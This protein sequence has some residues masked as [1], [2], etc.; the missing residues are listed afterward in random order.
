M[1]T[2]ITNVRV[3]EPGRDITAQAS[4]AVTAK[5][6][7][8]V[9][10]N[11]TGGNVAVATADAGGRVFGVAATDAPIGGL[12]RVARGGVVKIVAAGA[13]AAF[14]EVQSATGGKVA[15][16]STGVAIGQ[17]ITGAADAVDAEIALY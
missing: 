2:T 7:V 17:A 11:R 9:S 12:V 3:Y 5:T 8:K 4:A 10:G 13:I 14:A 16:K 15:T 1:S 6:L